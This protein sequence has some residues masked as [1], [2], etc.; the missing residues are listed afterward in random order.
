MNDKTQSNIQAN[1]DKTVDIKDFKF[2][3]KRDKELGTQRPAV[4]LKLPVPSIEGIIEILQTGGKGLELLQDAVA[5]IIATQAR[6]IINEKEDISQDNFPLTQ[7]TWEFIASM[8]PK[9]RRGGGISKE[10]WE[11]F[12]KD[13]VEVMP[14]VTGKTSEQVGNAA[15][16]FLNKFA[17]IKTNKPAL[18]LLKDQLALYI[19]N[20]TN[21][22]TFVECV[23]FLNN[24]A[25]TLLNMSEAD[26]LANL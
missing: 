16:I 1:Y 13:Y 14:A 22:E 6:S 25:D 9:E 19:T 5:D 24:K 21:A 20:S 8:P 15:K 12:A 10:V 3:F 7:I 23:D 26:L 11:D 2:N 18:R 4:E 17:A